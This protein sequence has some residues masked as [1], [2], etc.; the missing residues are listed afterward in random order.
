MWA[1]KFTR[2]ER[3]RTTRPRTP[4]REDRG[5]L[6]RIGLET[7]R[8]AQVCLQ[9]VGL[10]QRRCFGNAQAALSTPTPGRDERGASER[11]AP[12]DA[13]VEAASEARAAPNPAKE[14]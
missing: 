14:A 13:C 6:G 2:P 11:S 8:G 4:T 3:D 10:G 12:S 1:A 7:E 9:V 5:W